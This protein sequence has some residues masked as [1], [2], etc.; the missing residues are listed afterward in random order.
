MP[1]AQPR[2]A[3]GG[4]GRRRSC[5]C[6]RVDMDTQLHVGMRMYR[7][8]RPD[9][10]SGEQPYWDIPEVPPTR[11]AQNRGYRIAYYC[12]GSSGRAAVVLQHGLTQIKESF[13]EYV[14][15]F[16]KAG[17][18]AIAIDSLGHGESDKPTE[19]SVYCRK[20]RAADV[21]AVLDAEGISKAHFIGYSM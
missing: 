21:I 8:S 5:E 18:Y 11:Y 10:A 1:H 19:T 3:E 20:Q 13:Q 12:A 6:Q 7:G 16:V 17:Y 14:Q 4:T 2:A 9:M 15:E